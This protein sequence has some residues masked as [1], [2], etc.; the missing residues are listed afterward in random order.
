MPLTIVN[1]FK[2]VHFQNRKCDCIKYLKLGD[3][4]CG[5]GGMFVQSARFVQNHSGN[6]NSIS[7][8]GQ[9]ANATTRKMALMNLAIRGIEAN[10]GPH[11]ADTFINDLHPTLK[12]D[13]VMAIIWSQNHGI[14]DVH[15]EAHNLL[16]A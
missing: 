4:C 1:M 10:L 11:Q 14:Q 7:V 5:S 3:P 15:D 6:I 9:E 16:A 12:A 2:S 8:F 13:F